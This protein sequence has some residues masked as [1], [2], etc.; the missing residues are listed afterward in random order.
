M[1]HAADSRDISDLSVNYI[2]YIATGAFAGLTSLKTLN[3]EVNS[4]TSIANTAFNMLSSLT[5]L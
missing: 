1:Y 2:T 3:V 4:L 5:S